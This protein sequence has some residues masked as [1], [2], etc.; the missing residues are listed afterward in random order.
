M[1]KKP[2]GRG[3][4]FAAPPSYVYAPGVESWA[5]T[6]AEVFRSQPYSIKIFR[7]LKY[8]SLCIIDLLN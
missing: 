4:V 5:R 2:D 6:W 1:K 7:E 8:S 3:V